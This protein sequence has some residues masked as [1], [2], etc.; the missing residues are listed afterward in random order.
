MGVDVMKKRR[1][2]LVTSHKKEKELTGS[3]VK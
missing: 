1:V 3:F 2:P